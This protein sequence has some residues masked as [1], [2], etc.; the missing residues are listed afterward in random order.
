MNE[1]RKLFTPEHFDC[2]K[3]VK[4]LDLG[5]VGGAEY[6][7]GGIIIDDCIICGCC[8]TVFSLEEY[9]SHCYMRA[10]RFASELDRA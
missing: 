7:H 10:C 9:F 5:D 1:T 3:Q 4:F 2:P 6:W 8:G